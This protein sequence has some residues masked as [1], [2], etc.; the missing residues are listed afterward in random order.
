M[1]FKGIQI[2]QTN[3]KW[4]SITETYTEHTNSYRKTILTRT[5]LLEHAEKHP[6]DPVL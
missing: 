2:S 3:F 4:R 1:S 5:F 6:I